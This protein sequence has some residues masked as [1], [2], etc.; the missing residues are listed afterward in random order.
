MIC[1]RL[2]RL[3]VLAVLL[4]ATHAFSAPPALSHLFPAG[5]Q[6][7]TKVVVTCSGQFAWPIKVFASGVEAAC[8]NDSGK[9]EITIPQD[10]AADRI[11]L[12]LYNAEGASATA[13]FL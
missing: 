5:G 9:L 3:L 4:P 11:W 12:R 2:I 6:R 8:T 10:L 13:P 7:G 1:L